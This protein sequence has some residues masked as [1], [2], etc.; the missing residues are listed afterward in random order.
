MGFHIKRLVSGPMSLFTRLLLIVLVAFCGAALAVTFTWWLCEL[1]IVSV[2]AGLVA[3]VGI[4][5]YLVQSLSGEL[6]RGLDA[7]DQGVMNLLDGDYSASLS[8]STL[9]DLS[10]AQN[11]LNQL[12][13]QL[14][15][16]RQSVYQRELLLDTIIENSDLCVVLIDQRSQVIFSNQIARHWFNNGNSISGLTIQQV[17]QNCPQLL[18]AVLARRSGIFALGQEREPLCLLSCGQFVL[19][20]QRHTLIMLRELTQTLNRQEAQ[21][22]KKVIRVVSHE[23]NNSLAPISSLAHS[24]KLMLE[25][26]LYEDLADVFTTLVARSQYLADFV[27]RYATIAKLPAPQKVEVEWGEFIES[28]LSGT[29]YR[30]VGSVPSSPGIFDK[31]QMYQAVQNLLKNASESGADVDTIDIAVSQTSNLSTILISDRGPGM[32]EAMLK[33]ALM[34]FYSTKAGGT[35]TGLP[36]CREIV[37]SHGGTLTL[38]NR[39]SGGLQVK[40]ELPLSP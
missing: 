37:E 24:G 7:L 22:W 3:A 30:H 2:L 17:M 27:G 18:A 9:A 25:Q 14:R 32:N 23:L 34:P 33:K 35:G 19:H 38:S 21:A 15:Q 40:I 26:G 1:T 8:G 31:S 12:T 29:C 20:A 11:R 36:L 4:A 5:A 10:R 28:V 6:F 13:Q 39:A 16:E